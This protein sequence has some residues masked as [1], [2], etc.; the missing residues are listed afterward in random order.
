ME[1]RPAFGL[2]SRGPTGEAADARKAINQKGFQPASF[3]SFR[4]GIGSSSKRQPEDS[5]DAD[6]DVEMAGGIG[7]SRGGIGSSRGGIGSS[8]SSTEPQVSSSYPTF[9]S[10][11]LSN[12]GVPSAFGG[13][14]SPSVAPSD[15]FKKKRSFLP[16]ANN[17]SS[18]STGIPKTSI[19]FGSGSGGGFNPAAMMA[20]MGW[21]GGGL[22]KEG[23]GIVNPVEVQLRPEKAGIAFGGRKEK[24]KQAKEEARR[25]GEQVSSDEEDGRNRRKGKESQETRA[26]KK[27]KKEVQ[28]QNQSQAWTKAEKKPRKPKVEHRTYEQIIEAAGGIPDVDSSIGQIIDATGSE[29]REINS[30]ASA[31]SR[32]SVPTSDSTRLP[33]LRHNLRLI[34]DQNKQSLDL[35][36]KDGANIFDRRRWLKRESEEAKRRLEAEEIEKKRLEEILQIVREIENLGKK[37]KVDETVELESFSPLVER[38]VKDFDREIKSHAL[39][40]AVVGSIVPIVSIVSD[41]S[42][43]LKSRRRIFSNSSL[44]SRSLLIGSKDH[45]FLVTSRRSIPH[46]S[47]LETLEICTSNF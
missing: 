32:H 28:N 29:L 31:L 12:A 6:G 23:E 35:L 43:K 36:A 40:E 7:S 45:D 27:E 20:K 14:A 30:L 26:K 9:A 13:A 44:F 39:D 4:G 18:S 3:V 19:K 24:T 37:A 10:S 38:L 16:G 22:G 15:A 25:R 11:V 42:V 47:N 1:T 8:S 34:C 2:G 46:D 21:T 33:E 41:L 17:S 5:N